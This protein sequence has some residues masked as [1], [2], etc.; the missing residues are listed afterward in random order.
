MANTHGYIQI[1]RDIARETLITST[2]PLNWL[3]HYISLQR[4][5][6]APFGLNDEYR[7]WPSVDLSSVSCTNRLLHAQ[8][9]PRTVANGRRTLYPDSVKIISVSVLP[10][11]TSLA[12]PPLDKTHSRSLIPTA[13]VRHSSFSV[14]DGYFKVS[15]LADPFRRFLSQGN[16][17]NHALDSPLVSPFGLSS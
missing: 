15:L 11:Q 8:P 2:L 6:H 5:E 1:E 16:G 7:Y 4:D 12:T 17:N 10:C 9:G 13:R 14:R 3:A